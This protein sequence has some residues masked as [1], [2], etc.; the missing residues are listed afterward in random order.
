[1]PSNAFTATNNTEHEALL[2]WCDGEDKEV[3]YATLPPG[4]SIRQET[5]DGHI[6]RLRGSGSS[7]GRDPEMVELVFLSEL[8]DQPVLMLGEPRIERNGGGGGGSSGEDYAKSFYKQMVSV[9][10]G[11]MTAKAAECVSAGAVIAA[12]EIARQM[13]SQSSAELVDRLAAHKC[14][15]A[16]IGR[17]QVTSDIPE[18]REWCLNGPGRPS[19]EEVMAAVAAT[20]P[21][22]PGF[23]ATQ[24]AAMAS[25][26]R[27]RLDALDAPALR[28]LVSDLVASGACSDASIRR[29]LPPPP[30]AAAPPTA[31]P[32]TAAPPTAAPPAA[33]SP[34]AAAP[35][36]P[37]VAV[38]TTPRMDASAP[39]ELV[40][41]DGCGD[42]AAAAAEKTKKSREKPLLSYDE[43]T[44]GC[45]G[46]VVCSVGE[47]NLLDIDTDPKFREESILVHEFGHT[48]KN[49]GL[50][51]EAQSLVALAH[52]HACARGLY[53]P[54]AAGEEGTPCYM[55]TNADEYWAEGTQS[56]FDATMR[57]DVNAG[58]NCRARL[59]AH[60]PA[61]ALLLAHAYGEGAWRFTHEVRPE[62]RERWIRRQ[63]AGE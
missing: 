38:A 4:K 16:I 18:H 46:G 39:M 63:E 2:L 21:S 31:A 51:A 19:E 52:R 8:E 29:V 9:G 11:G 7:S 14:A 33:A 22:E 6:W 24:R 30:P 59:Q 42:G 61:L 3:T 47:E 32:P 60:D 27:P 35:S 34:A 13:L 28:Q 48:V 56:W 12:A 10:V 25:A 37:P 58:V 53:P 43:T 62:T 41:G 50:S 45:G 26:L 1:M 17:D 57:R 55:A 15:I 40:D 54:H 23:E 49:L 36:A 5:F 20:T 44:R